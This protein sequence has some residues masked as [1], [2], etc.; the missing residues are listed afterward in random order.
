[1]EGGEDLG[2]SVSQLQPQ[3]PRSS[4]GCSFLGSSLA[5]ASP[6]IILATALTPRH[7]ASRTEQRRGRGGTQ[8]ERWRA[9]QLQSCDAGGAACVVY[10]CVVG[11][12]GVM[13]V[14]IVYLFFFTYN[15]KK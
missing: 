10:W 9:K 8:K 13:G 11:G 3:D 1:M 6:A 2:Q 5:L 4:S 14:L 15:M 12:G 7:L